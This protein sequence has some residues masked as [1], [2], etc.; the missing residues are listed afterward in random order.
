M[1]A[2]SS[3]MPAASYVT[4]ERLQAPGS[5]PRL[6]ITRGPGSAVVHNIEITLW[7]SREAPLAVEPPTGLSITAA[8]GLA[9]RP[10]DSRTSI[11]RE[12]GLH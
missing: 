12:G 10:A 2:R 1:R 4:L 8:G 7:R 3:S 6:P 9:V 11:V 5:I